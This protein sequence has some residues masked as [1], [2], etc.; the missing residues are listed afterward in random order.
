LA[1]IVARKMIL[2]QMFD[3]INAVRTNLDRTNVLQTNVVRTHIKKFPLR[4]IIFEQCLRNKWC[5]KKY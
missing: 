3:R 4:K 2:E 5:K 1:T